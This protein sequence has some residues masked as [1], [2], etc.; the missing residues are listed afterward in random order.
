MRHQ[1]DKERWAREA[2]EREREAQDAERMRRMGSDLS[3]EEVQRIEIDAYKGKCFICGSVA[4]HTDNDPGPYCQK[5]D[6]QYELEWIWCDYA[7]CDHWCPID[8]RNNHSP[9]FCSLHGGTDY[10]PRT[11][12]ER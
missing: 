5:H 11:S 6:A 9:G 3:A 8:E 10:Q 1:E 2:I 7:G 12:E 4:I